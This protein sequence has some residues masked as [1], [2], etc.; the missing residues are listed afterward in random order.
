M[1]CWILQRRMHDRIIHCLKHLP[2]NSVAPIA[3]A[4]MPFFTCIT[5]FC[6]L[7][8]SS[9]SAGTCNDVNTMFRGPVNILGWVNLAP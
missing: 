2:Q 3:Y 1:F 7:S 6:G 9:L 4:H 5:S 8:T